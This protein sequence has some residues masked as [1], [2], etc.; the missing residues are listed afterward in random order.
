M[1]E[2]SSASEKDHIMKQDSNKQWVEA[3]LRTGAKVIRAE[4]E[5]RK[6]VVV[7]RQVVLLGSHNPLSQHHSREVMLACRG[8]AFA[9]RLLTDLEAETHGNPPVCNQCG[10]AFELWRSAARMKNMPYFWRCRPCRIDRNVN[11]ASG[12][13]AAH[14]TA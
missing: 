4:V 14:V 10:R 8:A 6:I 3:L 13:A 11:A 1:C 9:E 5:H 7:D 2:Y 12:G